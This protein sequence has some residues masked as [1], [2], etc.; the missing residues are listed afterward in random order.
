MENQSANQIYM[1]FLFTIS[2]CTVR[3]TSIKDWKITQGTK[4]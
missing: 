3:T 2:A 1:Y 4:R